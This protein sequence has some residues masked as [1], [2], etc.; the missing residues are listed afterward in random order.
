MEKTDQIEE[1]CCPPLK[2]S[3]THQLDTF[4]NRRDA[5]NIYWATNTE[6]LT[7]LQEDK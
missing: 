7:W 2:R 3:T 4:K 6:T 1:G 5:E